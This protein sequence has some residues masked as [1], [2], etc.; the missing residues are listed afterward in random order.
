MERKISMAVVLAIS[1]GIVFA[2]LSSVLSVNGA[3]N[4]ATGASNATKGNL[5]SGNQSGSSLQSTNASSTPSVAKNAGGQPNATKSN[6]TQGGATP[7]NATGPTYANQSKNATS[8]NPLAKIGETLK[9]L[10][11]GGKK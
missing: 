9:G 2:S 1:L 8:A 11:G 7:T 10:F 4:N 6:A 5:T 3:Q